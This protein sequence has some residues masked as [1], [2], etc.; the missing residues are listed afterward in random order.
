MTISCVP[1]SQYLC[2]Q[3]AQVSGQVR[4]RLTTL[5][6][7]GDLLRVLVPKGV[8][9]PLVD[10]R[11]IA[12]L[13]GRGGRHGDG[14]QSLGALGQAVDVEDAEEAQA[15][16]LLRV[17]LMSSKVSFCPIGR[18]C[19]QG[20]QLTSFQMA[21]P[22]LLANRLNAGAVRLSCDSTMSLWNLKTRG[23][24]GPSVSL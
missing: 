6:L 21:W 14:G 2:G 22:L 20:L 10:E 5:Q 12:D 4:D 11:L 9:Q 8:V 16:V 23:G 24:A 18:A 17:S 15:D 1:L 19:K 13:E 3:A 7:S